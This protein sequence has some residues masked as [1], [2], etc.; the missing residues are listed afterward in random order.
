MPVPVVHRPVRGRRTR[1]RISSARAPSYL[2]LVR[3]TSTGTHTRTS[4][5]AENSSVHISLLPILASIIFR[6][7]LASTLPVPSSCR[8]G[9]CFGRW[10]HAMHARRL[11]HSFHR[12]PLLSYSFDASVLSRQAK[13]STSLLLDSHHTVDMF[14]PILVL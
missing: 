4:H 1:T 13:Q 11:S 14:K 9:H 12:C 10:V 3:S 8:F 2:P 5:C 6:S 7:I